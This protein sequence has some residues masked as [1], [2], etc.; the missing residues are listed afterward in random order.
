MTFPVVVEACDG[1]FAAS[2]VAVPN[3]RVVG[4]TRSQAIDAL[5][6][7]LEHRVARGELLSRDIET[8][9]VSSLAGKYEADPTR[10]TIGDEAYQLRDAEGRG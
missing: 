3:V 7:E 8:I 1:Q 2:L 5:R 6:E 9:G 4:S 10:C